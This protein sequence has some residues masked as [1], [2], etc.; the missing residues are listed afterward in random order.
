[1]RK[2]FFAMYALVGALV[3]SPVFTSCIDGEE[4]ASV[5]AVRNA[6]AEQIKNATAIAQA[7]AEYQEKMNALDLTLKQMQV[8]SNQISL[9]E[10]KV[11]FEK[12]KYEAEQAIAYAKYYT[13]YYTKNLYQYQD[14]ILTE[15]TGNYTGALDQIINYKRDIYDSNA[16]I[17]ALENGIVSIDEQVATDTKTY[18]DAIA[19]AEAKIAIWKDAEGGI[20]EAALTAEQTS[21]TE[22]KNKLSAEKDALD[23]DYAKLATVLA[24]AE[25][26]NLN[27]SYT[28][29]SVTRYLDFVTVDENGYDVLSQGA[30]TVYNQYIA[31]QLD[32]T[33]ATVA[34]WEKALAL[35]VAK[36]GT[37]ADKKD[38]K[39]VYDTDPTTFADLKALTMYAELAVAKEDLT[40]KEKT[41]KEK[42]EAYDKAKAAKAEKANALTKAQDDLAANTDPTKVQ[43]LTDAVT[44]AQ[45][46]YNTADT[47]F[48]TA[49]TAYIT[50][51]GDYN[52]AVN[53]V[54]DA[55]VAIA[56]TK[57]NI[58]TYTVNLA[59][60]K[61]DL[62]NFAEFETWVAAFE[63]EDYE[64]YKAA[65]DAV[66]AKDTEITDIDAEITA[67]D[68]ILNG[69]LT[70]IKA[71]IATE[72]E[73]IATNKAN[74]AALEDLKE[75][76]YES[77]QTSANGSAY[78]HE[79]TKAQLEALI[80]IYEENIATLEVK[81]EMAEKRAEQAKAA[82]DAYLATDEEGGEAEA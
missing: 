29:N 36:L 59:T 13:V 1:M 34:T 69:G 43:T 77:I 63:G 58:N 15:L 7:Q 17:Y 68:A 80:E 65:K 19:A 41:Y 37:E 28:V 70:D 30:V 54:E 18:N 22:K 42:K 72:E 82:L 66:D 20:D 27:G 44:A 45:T 21:L 3:A 79:F 56:Q 2:K 60:A 40:A 16:K 73:T 49:E 24:K 38:T 78:G 12:V 5:T 10:K 50:A 74:L 14:E 4:S 35:E 32:N 46:A 81:L 39:Y 75:A 53:A 76:I 33:E 55:E 26:D 52:G 51:E 23:A 48:G 25:L 71:L 47:A 57:D 11:N 6:K 62:D 31:E 64:A 8:E 67:I 9:E 61:E